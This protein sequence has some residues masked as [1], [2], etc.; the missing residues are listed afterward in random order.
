VKCVILA[1]GRGT[2]IDEE[3]HLRPKPLIEIGQRP[4]LWHIMKHYS[5]H[6]VHEFIVCLGY[7]GYM[8]K[9][10]FANYFL[11]NSDVT[12]DLC[13]N[14]VAFHDS[15]SEPWRVTLVDTGE[16]TLTGG[17][18]R[19]VA[20]YLDA[21][22]PFFLTYGDG[23][24]DVDLT[25]ELAFHRAHGRLATMTVVRPPARFG[26]S[27]VDGD[28]VVAFAEKHQASEGLINGGFFVMSPDALSVIDGDDTPLETVVLE[29][30]VAMDQMRAWRHQGFWQ[31]MDTLREKEL[32]DT[33]WRRD[34]APWRVW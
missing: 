19:R 1:G 4:I 13:D 5:H 2:R 31:P 20:R 23:V 28:R 29:R 9:E 32:L 21:S 17:R 27:V 7:R 12:V 15:R 34:E 26:S 6:G 11:H 18:V 25:A 24:A 3:S 10:Y 22:E 8:V 14:T 30:L 33:M 16:A